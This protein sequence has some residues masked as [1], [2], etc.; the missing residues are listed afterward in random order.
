MIH[1]FPDRA[2]R[3]V[4]FSAEQGVALVRSP[5]TAREPMIDLMF[6]GVRYVDL[7]A[8]LP[9]GLE[10]AAPDKTDL[11]FLAGRLEAPPAPETV[12]VLKTRTKRYRVVAAGL[13]V[14][15]SMLAATESPF[16]TRP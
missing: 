4:E 15:E 12:F 11:A 2:F 16:P 14:A 8:E 5:K 10:I 7:A 9:A 3:F 6:W 13:K 1:V